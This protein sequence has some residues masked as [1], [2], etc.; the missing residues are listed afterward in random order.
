MYKGG[1]R[2][3]PRDRQIEWQN[4]GQ[5][6]NIT[7]TNHRRVLKPYL[8]WYASYLTDHLI[9]SILIRP[10]LVPII[11]NIPRITLAR[12]S[13]QP[14]RYSS[15]VPII[16]I[17]PR[18][19]YQRQGQVIICHRYCVINYFSLPLI[20]ASWHKC[21]IHLHA[22][23]TQIYTIYNSMYIYVYNT[24]I[25]EALPLAPGTRG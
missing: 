4:W 9:W 6:T 19:R 5:G 23:Q 14:S 20:P 17:T 15:L 24:K 7:R 11:P 22:P 16:C 18:S 1:K 21:S 8:H 2:D 13:P 12:I 3:R 10:S 25:R